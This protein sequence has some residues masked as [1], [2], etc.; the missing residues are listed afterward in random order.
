M[1]IDTG[2]NRHANTLLK[3][4][5]SLRREGQE[6]VQ[7]IEVGVYRGAT[8]QRILWKCPWVK[9]TLI[10]SWTEDEN[11]SD[12]PCTQQTQAE[13]D[14]NREAARQAVASIHALNRTNWF[15][16][17]SLVAAQSLGGTYFDLVFLDAD[18]RYESVKA[19]IQAWL[20]KVR[21]GGILCG[22]D[23]KQESVQRAVKEC[24]PWEQIELL[25]GLV[26]SYRKP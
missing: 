21:S 8:A 24:L 26:W 18:H 13:H 17:E 4:L 15:Y 10:D 2:G 6:Y 12:D 20:P 9:M 11:P 7:M 22:H 16:G 25:R 19:D 3:L 5:A 1:T 23:S 14:A